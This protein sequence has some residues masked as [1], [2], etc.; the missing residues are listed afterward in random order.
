MKKAI[1]NAK[2]YLRRGVFAEAV[3]IEDGYIRAAGTGAE[4]RSAAGADAETLDARGRLL[5]PGFFDC[6]LHLS[7]VGRQAQMIDAWGLT[8]IE[9]IIRRGREKL[10][11][12]K[13]PPGTVVLGGG[14]NQEEFTGDKRY[15]NRLDLDQISREHPIIIS[16]VCGHVAVGNTKALEMA[17]VAESAPQVEG[18]QVDLDEAGRPNGVFRE[19]AAAL[20][21]AIVPP[22][23]E[24]ELRRDLA[25]AMDQ[26]LSYGVTAAASFDTVGPDI[27]NVIDAF[28]QIY[29]EGGPRLRVTMQCGILGGEQYLDEYIRLGYT[30]GTVFYDPYLKMGP[31]KLF[32]D[33]SL[34]SRTAWMR[35]PY[36]DSPDTTG[37]TVT[38]KDALTALVSK[39][40]AHGLQAAIHAIGDAAVDAVVSAYEAVT[41]S[42]HNP[43]R[44]GV[45][46]CQITDAELLARMRRNDLL[47][48]VQP[49]F[50]LHDLYMA[51]SRVGP[52]LAASSYAWAT[53]ERLGI[54]SAY[55]TDCPVES[56]D[57]IQGIACAVTRKDPAADY[58]K[59]GFYPGECVDV[60][61]AV[62]NYTAGT[63]YA[64]FEE[65]RMGRIRPGAL[66]D[67][68]LLDRDIFSIPPA[69]IHRAKVAATLVG[70]ELV[71]GEI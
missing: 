60:Y 24:G 33:G 58:P 45:L 29:R 67:L 39:A 40:S 28:S 4:I 59:E 1:V 38:G 27:R 12:L 10:A 32:S 21:R 47:A 14:F 57:P 52:E 2:V 43:L 46:H 35:Q 13:P 8:S 42:G 69:E 70:G 11:Q 51:E 3:L 53:M 50:L 55:G 37:L 63:A 15:P 26:A 22:L 48:L 17:G 25:C 31:L 49:I 62:D 34:G 56:M 20:L 7:S 19:G 66:A 65:Q 71:Y 61:T 41:A 18:G 5:L 23:S 44:H 54:R 36:H 64:N 9:A 6:H 16:R 30:T 68:A